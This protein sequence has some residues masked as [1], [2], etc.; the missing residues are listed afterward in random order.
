MALTT[1]VILFSKASRKGGFSTQ[2]VITV[3]YNIYMWHLAFL[4]QPEYKQF[5]DVP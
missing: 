2:I 1:M 3:L 4:Y 5:T